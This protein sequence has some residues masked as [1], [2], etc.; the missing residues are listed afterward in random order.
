MPTSM[1]LRHS[2]YRVWQSGRI[3]SLDESSSSRADDTTYVFSLISTS[4]NASFG[5][6]RNRCVFGRTYEC[7]G[8]ML[9]AAFSSGEI[10]RNVPVACMLRVGL[11]PQVA[12]GHLS[13][14]CLLRQLLTS[15]FSSRGVVHFSSPDFIKWKSTTRQYSNRNH[16]M[17]PRQ[18]VDRARMLCHLQRRNCRSA[19]PCP[20]T[21]M[22]AMHWMAYLG[23]S[24]HNAARWRE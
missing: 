14:L 19:M 21:A 7:W 23:C 6:R 2:Q 1:I 10:S 20:P 9:A 13:H 18:L 8:L 22:P 4:R 16:N 15:R 11:M 5:R 12:S 17:P 24:N 3:E